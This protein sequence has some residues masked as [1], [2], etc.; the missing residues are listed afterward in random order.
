MVCFLV[1]YDLLKMLKN[2]LAQALLYSGYIHVF[3]RRRRA[4]EL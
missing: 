3:E 4:K 1:F 2:V